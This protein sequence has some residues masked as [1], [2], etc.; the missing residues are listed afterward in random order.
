MSSSTTKDCKKTY[1]SSG[2]GSKTYVL[3]SAISKLG[4]WNESKQISRRQ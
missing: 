2:D 3:F 1:F 4:L